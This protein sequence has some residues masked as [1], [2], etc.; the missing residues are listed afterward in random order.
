MHL[1][2]MMTKYAKISKIKFLILSPGVMKHICYLLE[3]FYD[4]SKKI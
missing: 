2:A 1:Y 4:L 3:F